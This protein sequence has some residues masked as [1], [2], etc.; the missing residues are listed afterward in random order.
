M[1]QYKYLHITFLIALMHV[2]LVAQQAPQFS[3]YMYNTIS[4]N[5]AYAGS[6]EI[7]VI[8]LLNRSQWVGVKGAPN[9]QTLSAHTSLPNTKL[10]V[11]LSLINDKL[12]YEKITYAFADLSYTIDFDSFDEYKLALGVKVGGSKYSLDDDL[13][14]DPE[15]N[16]DIFLDTV[17][18][19]FHPNIGV[20][21]YFRGPNFYLGFS[22][23]KLL[24]QVSKTDY[25]YTNRG[26]YFFNGGYLL[27]VNKHLKFKPSF[28]I[29]YTDGAPISF[30]LS[31]MFYINEKIWIG[32][33]YRVHD[34]FGALVNFKMAKGLSIGYAYDYITSNLGDF[35]SGSHEIMLNYEFEFPKPKCKCKDLYN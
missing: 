16:G 11:G 8:N 26:S 2:V 6:R 32:G 13:L 20:G 5:P 29:K 1:K 24:S 4:I 34:A 30:D 23:P 9:T 12:G 19:K 28:I 15:Y 31:T 33:S 22:A 25:A 17:D 7:M 3:Q 35:S 18:Y 14:N 21:V 10:G 27:D